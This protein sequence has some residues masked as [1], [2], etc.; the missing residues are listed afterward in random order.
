MSFAPSFVH[1]VE[2]RCEVIQVAFN[3]LIPSWLIT[4]L[5]SVILPEINTIG[6]VVRGF[7][8]HG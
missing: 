1:A 4:S 8:R 5:S 3:A 7:V 2:I 6:A